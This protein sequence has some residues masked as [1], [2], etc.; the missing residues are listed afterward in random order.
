MPELCL[1]A[2]AAGAH[3]GS[4]RKVLQIGA[5]AGN[6]TVADVLA[7][8]Y[9]RKNKTCGI[10]GRHVLHAVNRQV[11]S[12]GKKR[13]FQVLNENTFRPCLLTNLCCRGTLKV[14]TRGTNTEEFGFNTVQLRETL[15]DVIGLPQSERAAARRYT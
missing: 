13:L 11:R 8:C 2:K 12:S 1:A 9:R 3:A 7:F 4:R 15:A 6:Q 14:V 10:F 5:I